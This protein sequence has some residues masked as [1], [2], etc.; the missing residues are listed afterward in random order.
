[1][2]ATSPGASDPRPHQPRPLTVDRYRASWHR[3]AR[4]MA[5][6]LL[7]PVIE[8][9]TP[10]TVLGQ[11]NLEGLQAPFIIA[12]NHNSHLDTAVLVTHLPRELTRD[13]AVGAAADYFY[14]RW[15][16]KATT[17]LFFNTYPIERSSAKRSGRASGMSQKLLTAGIPIA[18][19][20][21]GKRSRDGRLQPFKPGVAAL[22]QATGA[23]CV[24]IAL[25]GT[26]EAMPVGRAWP[27]SGRPEVT[28]LIGR[29]M[30]PEP[31]ETL[32]DFTDRIAGHIRTMLD[33]RTPYVDVGT[34]GPADSGPHGPG[35][36]GPGAEGRSRDDDIDPAAEEGA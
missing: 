12:A 29:P 4:R 33:L 35:A 24:P 28:L 18:I 17:S 3:L 31:E 8:S 32:R 11:D 25:I 34:T 6:G 13:L 30:S 16:V 19:F 1:M 9:T 2:T 7:R 23:P 15:W 14:S 26:H 10:V 27:R 22:A 36:Q 5:R 21:E 20:P